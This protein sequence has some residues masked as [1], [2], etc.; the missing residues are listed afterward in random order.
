MTGAA[1]A[2]AS[3]ASV[4]GARPGASPWAALHQFHVGPIHRRIARGL[5]EGKHY[6]RSWPAGTCLCLGISSGRRLVGAL[7]LGVGPT[8]AHSIVDGAIRGNC[9]T[10]T[11]FWLA[12][13]LPANTAS[14]VLG[15]VLRALRKNTPL[16]FVVTYADPSQGHLGTI[17]QA[18]NWIY[19]GLSEAMRLYDLGDGVARHS[20]SLGASFGSHSVRH[21]AARGV[22]VR[23]IPQAPKHRYVYFLE[24]GWRS[25][26][27]VPVPPYPKSE[28]SD[29]GS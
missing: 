22:P 4:L 12:D 21:F 9:L 17:Y 11:R 10:L 15:V 26:L 3:T 16:K 6:L 5:I 24:P 25:R 20:R 29:A 13:Q 8:N 1:S 28:V 23:T 14:R 18:T 27:R 7:T 19:T 2:G